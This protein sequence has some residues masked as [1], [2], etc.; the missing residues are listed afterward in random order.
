MILTPIVCW[1]GWKLKREG[2]G[3][4]HPTGASRSP[5][6]WDRQCCDK[7]YR[8][9]GVSASASS[10]PAPQWEWGPQGRNRGRGLGGQRGGLDTLVSSTAPR[11]TR[12]AGRPLWPP[13][14]HANS[15]WTQ[16][17]RLT[18]FVLITADQPVGFRSLAEQLHLQLPQRLLPLPPCSALR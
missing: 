9:S 14:G 18:P 12:V 3:K 11:N 6:P 2:K 4:S 17:S 13:W 5:R 16:E 7:Q 1:T 15:L 8:C 10:D